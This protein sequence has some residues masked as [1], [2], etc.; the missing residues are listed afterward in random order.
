MAL[1]RKRKLDSRLVTA[2]LLIV[3]SSLDK[4][5]PDNKRKYNT[6]NKKE[7][8]QLWCEPALVLPRR[9]R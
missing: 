3:T 9:S 6:G 8:V 1:N 7:L 5:A 2:N 4:P